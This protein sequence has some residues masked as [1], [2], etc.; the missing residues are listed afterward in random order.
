MEEKMETGNPI[1]SRLAGR[2]VALLQQALSYRS[3]NH[4]VISGNLANVDTP[5]YRP[6]EL[7]FDQELR[8]A[9]DGEGI[10]I[11]RTDERH[12]PTPTDI[13]GG[14]ASHE[15]VANDQEI[16]E[17]NQLN[18][19]KEMARMVQNNLLYEASAKLLAKRFDAL[20]QVIEG[21]R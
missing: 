9:V 14:K 20:R 21:R 7:T 6:Q 13:F 18:I 4:S 5:G 1:Q 2:T 3:A 19:D 16:G 17:S 10:S 11:K 8:R 12:M 15:L